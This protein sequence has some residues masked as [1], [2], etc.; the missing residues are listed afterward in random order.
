MRPVRRA[1]PAATEVAARRFEVVPPVTAALLGALGVALIAAW[2]VL[3]SL[4][5]VA[6]I[7]GQRSIPARSGGED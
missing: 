1:G 3:T 6:T 7:G 2:V 5:L 4:G